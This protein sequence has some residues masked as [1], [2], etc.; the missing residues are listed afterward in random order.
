MARSYVVERRG[1]LRRMDFPAPING[2][3]FRNADE[4]VCWDGTLSEVFATT[5]GGATWSRPAV[6]AAV[7]PLSPY[8]GAVSRFSVWN[9]ARST[10]CWSWG[11]VIGDRALLL[12][13]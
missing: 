4:F 8:T 2:C 13:R 1:A 6:D 11:C 12:P 9:N 10:G 5:T 3:S 7:A